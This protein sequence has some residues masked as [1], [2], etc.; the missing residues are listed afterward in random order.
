MGVFEAYGL[1]SSTTRRRRSTA[2]ALQAE[3]ED[4]G[5]WCS[6]PSTGT[7]FQGQPLD[8][9]DVLCRTHATCDRCGK[10]TTC[11]GPIDHGYTALF[12]PDNDTF[13]CLGIRV[14]FGA[15]FRR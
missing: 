11:T 1:V 5:C 8:E 9:L 10:L 3:V 2:A 14:T 4:Y 12:D 6:K 15:T 13:M 7:A